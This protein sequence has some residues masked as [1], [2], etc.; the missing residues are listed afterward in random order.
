MAG[1]DDDKP[2]RSWSEI[3]KMR[4]R[5]TH[6]REPGAGGG[7]GGRGRNLENTQAY[8]SYKTQLNK[9]F[10]GG[11]LPE[12]LKS[13]LEEKGVG[14]EAK[15]KKELASALSSALAPAAIRTALAAY[16]AEVGAFPDEEEALGKLLELEDVPVLLETIAT[17]DRLHGEGT[18]KR[19]ASLKAR[20]K[21]AQMTVDSP[22]VTEACRAL[23]G[24]L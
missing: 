2:K 6:R 8:R 3:D 12:A 10:D 5:S 1:D 20:L 18:L 13:K 24:K 19:G 15:R 4:D 21:T 9:L 22:K 23:L 11:G 14:L 16:R 7:G 17:L